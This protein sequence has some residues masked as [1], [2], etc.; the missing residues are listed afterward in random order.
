MFPMLTSALAR[1]LLVVVAVYRCECNI[2]EACGK[3]GMSR[4]PPP[5]HVQQLSSLMQDN[6]MSRFFLMLP[7]PLHRNCPH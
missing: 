4:L 6:N 1:L 2:L 3:A 7:A 5:M